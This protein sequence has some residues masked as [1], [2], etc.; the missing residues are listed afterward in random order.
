[1]VSTVEQSDSHDA[2]E[3]QAAVVTFRRTDDADIKDHQRYVYARIDDGPTHI[4][5]FGDVKVLEVTPGEHR[6]RANNTLFW[7]SLPFTAKPGEHIEFALINRAAWIHLGFIAYLIG[8]V[9][10]KLIIEQRDGAAR[11]TE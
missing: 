6:L 7:K 3:L 4:V 11:S 5:R 10:L 1:M 8:G 2:V 9:P